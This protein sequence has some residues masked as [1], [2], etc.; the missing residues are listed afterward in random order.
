MTGPKNTEKKNHRDFAVWKFN[1]ELG[2]DADFGKGF[3]GWHIE[4]SAMSRKYLEQPFD[5][6]TG[7]IDHIPI[8]HNNE[9]AQ[10]ESAYGVPL[11]KF[12]MHNAHYN[13]SGEKMAKSGENFITLKTLKEKNIDPLAL[14][15]L[16]LTARHSS[17][18]QFSWEAL[19]ASQIALKRLRKNVELPEVAEVTTSPSIDK[20]IK[21]YE[22][23]FIKFIN[24]DLDTPKVLALIWNLTQDNNVTNLNKRKLILDFDK[25]LGLRLD[26]KEIFDSLQDNIQKLVD[27]RNLSRSEKNFEKSDILRVEIEALGFQVKDTDEGTVLLPK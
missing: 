23:N 21:S 1:S 16:F 10:S 13:I 4:C 17:P 20:T 24:D 3:P 5:I 25:I 14:R 15:Y 6:H 9:I 19:E 11:A 22:E 27:E 12:W 7:G 18:L 8:H 26:E 2:Y